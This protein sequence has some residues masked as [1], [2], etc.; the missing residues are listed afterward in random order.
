MD[1]IEVKNLCK[2]Y[3]QLKAV[4]H[5]SFSVKKG[6]FFGLLGPN[7]AGKSTTIN[8]LTGLLEKDSGHISLL[9]KDP[10]TDWE[11]V[12]NRMNV[13][14]AYYP[15]TE[16]LTIRQNLRVYGRMYDIPKREQKIDEMLKQFEL[17]DLQHHRVIT[18]SSGERTRV[19]LCKGLLNDPELLFLDECTVGLDPDIAEKTRRILK[20][21]QRERHATFLFTSHYMHEVEELCGRIA[22]MNK[23]KILKIDTAHNLK[24][25]ITKMTVSLGIK[26]GKGALLKEFLVAEGVEVIF[27]E[28]NALI[29]EVPSR[30]EKVYKIMNKIFKKG[31]KLSDLHIQRPTLDDLFIAVARGKK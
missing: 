31:F 25:L 10:V 30:G 17:N 20:E 18:L 9:G 13:A 4:D 16:V 23:G 11:Y 22:F 5:I 1:V 12:K 27:A 14:T 24:K 2:S 28:N 19:A 6:E 26:E 8:M 3:G 7:G 29:F 21:Y 15:L